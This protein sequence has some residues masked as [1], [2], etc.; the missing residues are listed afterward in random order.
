MQVEIGRARLQPIRQIH[1]QWPAISVATAPQQQRE[2][3]NQPIY[4][5]MGWQRELRSLVHNMLMKQC[6]LLYKAH[7]H[8]RCPPPRR[9]RAGVGSDGKKKE[10]RDSPVFVPSTDP[11]AI[12]HERS[13]RSVLFLRKRYRHSEERRWRL[14]SQRTPPRAS[15]PVFFLHG[16]SA[17][18]RAD[19]ACSA[20]KQINT[21]T[22]CIP[23]RESFS[24]AG[25]NTQPVMRSALAQV[26]VLLCT[27]S[28]R[29]AYSECLWN[30]DNSK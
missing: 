2:E 22:V 9:K 13:R 10:D 11:S 5:P 7:R 17:P 23:S 20:L 12:L 28:H 6:L 8:A 30:T 19:S 21:Q 26:L 27:Y 18:S 3:H 24:F 29:G 15:T 16:Q 4:F 1:V 14:L 25:R